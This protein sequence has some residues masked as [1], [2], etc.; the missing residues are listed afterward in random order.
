MVI[1]NLYKHT[2]LESSF[3]VN[4][5]AID[6]GRPKILNLKE[7]IQCYIDH[8]REVVLRRAAVSGNA[9]TRPMSHS[10]VA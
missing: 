4:M 5:L 6:H 8:R 10:A 1:N 3:A 7:M 2:S 9:F